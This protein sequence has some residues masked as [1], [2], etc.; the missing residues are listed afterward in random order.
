M[1]N[2]IRE[3]I[4]KAL[5]NLSDRYIEEVLNF[6]GKKK[7]K[8]IWLRFTAIAACLAIVIGA[9]IA[10][11]MM[12]R[13]NKTNPPTITEDPNVQPGT[14]STGEDTTYYFSKI[15]RFYSYTDFKDFVKENKIDEEKYPQMHWQHWV[16][17]DFNLKNGTFIDVKK[18]FG[19]APIDG[20]DLELIYIYSDK[21]NYFEYNVLLS[22]NDVIFDAED[23]Y[24]VGVTYYPNSTVI[25]T[26][27]LTDIPFDDFEL[28]LK[29]IEARQEGV[30]MIEKESCKL[31]YYKTNG[32]YTRIEL[33]TENY[34]IHFNMGIGEGNFYNKQPQKDLIFDS[35]VVQ[36]YGGERAYDILFGKGEIN[37]E[38]E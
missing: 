29:E 18:M 26:D 5:D 27:I 30:F 24:T 25:N 20:K 28:R 6:E 3:D 38:K 8:N 14:E 13:P 31:L 19:F 1:K 22:G 9:I 37:I 4:S 10:V 7:N 2:T 12:I 16:R 21:D 11:P 32:Y 33:Y 23:Y 17:G 34:V 35:D 15:G 36:K